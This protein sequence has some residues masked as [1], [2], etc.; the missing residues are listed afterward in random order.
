MFCPA[1][2][3]TETHTIT[4]PAHSWSGGRE[5]A[6]LAMLDTCTGRYWSMRLVKAPVR[7]TA[8]RPVKSRLAWPSNVGPSLTVS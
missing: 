1:P 2:L 4:L 6:V 5:S 3:A 8:G 7:R